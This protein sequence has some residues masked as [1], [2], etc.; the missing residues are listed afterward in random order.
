MLQSF[1]AF[2]LKRHSIYDDSF[3]FVY[4]YFKKRDSAFLYT[5]FNTLHRA[6]NTR[7][8]KE[9]KHLDAGAHRRRNL[10]K[11]VR[12]FSDSKGKVK[13]KA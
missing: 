6:G 9:R 7:F 1:A 4:N 5:D 8:R 2:R 12:L 10:R 3:D 11:H 13:T